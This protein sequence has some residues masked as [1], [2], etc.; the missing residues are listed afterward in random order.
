MTSP[1]AAWQQIALLRGPK[2]DPG[3]T[4]P[5]GRGVASATINEDGRLVIVFSD[6]VILDLGPVIGEQG[7]PGQSVVIDGSVPT[8]ADL[9][10]LSPAD[11]G[12]GFISLDDGHLHVWLGDA[13]V[14]VGPVR[15]PKGDRGDKGDT[16]QRGS[17]W[18]N[19]H[20]PPQSPITG[21]QFGDYYLDVD[22]GVAYQLV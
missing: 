17:L 4:G 15:G 7:A 10:P 14:D 21:S 1:S 18:F 13:Y 8:A 2:G 11:A 20:G 22:S 6:G 19:G 16:G 12:T 9:T 3:G 5:A